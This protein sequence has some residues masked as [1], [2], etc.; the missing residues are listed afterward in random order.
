MKSLFSLQE[1]ELTARKLCRTSPKEFECKMRLAQ[2]LVNKTGASH[3]PQQRIK[4][5]QF[6][7]SLA[8]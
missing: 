5:C 8:R 6:W 7:V 2:L 3:R 4:S 1:T